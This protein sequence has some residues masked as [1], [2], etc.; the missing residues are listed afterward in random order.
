[1][2]N[3]DTRI[4]GDISKYNVIHNYALLKPEFD[5]VIVRIGY[6]GYSA[7]TIKEDD[8]F[9][10]HMKGLTE[11]KIP[12][13][14]Y[15]MGQAITESEAMAEAEYCFE[16]TREYSPVFPTY[17]DSE[18]SNNKGG[19]RADDLSRRDRTDIT[20][21][22]CR[23][24]EELGRR[25]GV[26]ASKS[27]FE[28]RLYAAELAKYSIWVARYNENLGYHE[29][30]YD[31]WQHTSSHVIPGIS[32]KFDRSYCYADFSSGAAPGQGQD[33]TGK[34]T[35]EMQKGIHTYSLKESGAKRLAINGAA[36]NFVLREFRCKDGSDEI[37][38]DYGL[39]ELLQKVRD[40]FGKP[41]SITSAYRTP[42]HNKSVNGATSS[43]HIKGQAA[44]FTVTGVSGREVAKYLQSIGARGIGLYDYTGGFV[45]V[46]TREKQY[47]WQQDAR[48]RKYYGVSSFGQVELYEVKGRT[49]ATVR[50]NDRNEWVRLL[51]QEIGVEADGIF[52]P[53]TEAAVR[54]IQKEHGLK[55]DGVVGPKTW[56]AVL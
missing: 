23:R 15:F 53:K 50:Y 44:D 47:Y 43:Y 1:M 10:E 39:V 29:T 5:G 8:R 55:V 35:L 2:A 46:D 11:Q 7:G 42:T 38:L 48:N 51:Q 18:L 13:G 45:H 19:G 41:V 30:A 40:H 25:A 33:A 49:V 54:A 56:D 28:T 22:F 34:Q 26:Y 9:R 37:L 4:V 31:M 14:F 12:Y 16:M 52:G 3:K 17:Y 27:W 32:T 36:A 6:R 20:L 24:M 21:A